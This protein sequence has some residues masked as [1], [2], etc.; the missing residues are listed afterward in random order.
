MELT[1]PQ[2][3]TLK[4][5]SKKGCILI[6][7]DAIEDAKIII[8]SDPDAPMLDSTQDTLVIYG[9]GDFEASG[10]LI[11]GSKLDG[12]VSYSIDADDSRI[13]FA[14]S[15]S[16]SR[17]T[18]EDDYD[19]V[20]IKAVEPV[21]ESVLSAI[22]SKLVVVY[23]DEVNIPEAIKQNRVN[24]INLKKIEDTSSNVVYLAKK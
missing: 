18:D 12:G 24:K 15:T 19:A 5:N 23:G 11:K 22:S 4:I 14:K 21:E 3:N 13:I 7:P 9:P 10:V 2:K 6:D 20:V 16:I 8:Q 1:I 17:L